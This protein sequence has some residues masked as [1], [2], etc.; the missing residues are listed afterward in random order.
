MNVL[1]CTC[2]GRSDVSVKVDT[3]APVLSA[4][5]R[6]AL[7]DEPFA[8]AVENVAP[9]ARVSIRSRL[10]DDTGVTWSAATMFRADDRGRVDLRRDAPAPGGSYDGVEPLGRTGSRREAG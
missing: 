2:S 9:G 10:V 7:V 4:T 5:P 6:S 1:N 8:I 3:R